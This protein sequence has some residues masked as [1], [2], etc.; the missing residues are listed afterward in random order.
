MKRLSAVGLMLTMGWQPIA[1]A[2]LME[3][4][5]ER[6]AARLARESGAGEDRPGWRVVQQLDPRSSVVVAT[7][8]DLVVGAFVG[9][10]A[11]SIQVRRNGVIEQVDADAVLTVEKR[12]RRGS[13]VAATLGA[14]G[15]LWLGS[16]LALWI[17]LESRCQPNCGGV[18]A[19]MFGAVIG[20][21]I[22]AGYGA[23]RSTSRMAEEV[24]YRRPSKGP[25]R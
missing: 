18:E 3:R 16:G 7:S 23:W 24:I 25:P 19:M 22:A 10:D 12:V 2:G 11:A 4:A 14:L 21:P 17:G 8:D 13:A 15:G 5:V 9:A 20:M 1:A 6:E